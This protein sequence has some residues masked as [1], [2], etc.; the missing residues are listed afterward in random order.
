MLADGFTTRHGPRAELRPPRRRPPRPARAARARAWPRSPRAARSPRPA[1]TPSCS[2]RRARNV[3]TRQRGLRGREHRRRRLPARQHELPDPARRAGPRPRRGRAR[4]G[5]EHPVLARRS[6]G[7]QRRAVARRSRGCARTSARGSRATDARRRSPR[8]LADDRPRRR[9]GAP[10]R[11]LPRPRARRARRAADAGSDRHRAL[12]RRVGRHAARRP[13]AVRQPPQPRLGPGAAQALLPPLQL[14]AAGGGDRGRDRP[15]ALDQ[16]Q[17]PARR[18]RRATCTRR[19]RSTC[20]C[21]RC[22]TR[23]CSPCAGAGTRPRRWRC[24]A[25]PAAGRSRRSCSA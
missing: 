11:R 2:S 9:G 3:G 19:P 23:R 24:R 21:R 4:R 1:T 17:L 6:A 25:S 13:L 22:S 10:D 14:R 18:G 12:L 8:W 16:P 15:V 7:P 5:A 20:W